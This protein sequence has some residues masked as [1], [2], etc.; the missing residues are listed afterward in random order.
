MQ[1][2]IPLMRHRSPRFLPAVLLASLSLQPLLADRGPRAP[3]HGGDGPPFDESRIDRLAEHQAERLT[4]ALDLSPEQQA[5]LGRL[6]SQLESSLR[7]L[8][9][10]ARTAREQLRTL[11]AANSPDPAAVGAQAIALDR[12]RDALHD[13]W[14]RFET[15]FMAS[16]SPTQ[17]AAYRVLKESRPGP[18]G[19]G[20][21]R[22]GRRH[23]GP[24]GPDRP[25]DD[26]PED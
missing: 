12:S 1:K 21:H 7:P 25:G 15:D 16:L 22:D 3:R 23:R 20:G 13:A 18:R 24:G 26:G 8:G 11:L 4:R 14:E 17:R 2:E 9:E 6:Q 19:F 5:T 10:T